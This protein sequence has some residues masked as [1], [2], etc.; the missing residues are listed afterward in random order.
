MIAYKKRKKVNVLMKDLVNKMSEKELKA[1][2]KE[3]ADFNQ[4]IR[5]LRAG[6]KVD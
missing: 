1:L 6:K 5:K 4:K 3:I 2:A